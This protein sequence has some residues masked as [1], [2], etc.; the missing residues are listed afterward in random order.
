MA[1]VV[2]C[3][4]DGETLADALGSLRGQEPHELVVVDDGSTDA[5]TLGALEE[6][7]RDGVRV[8]R[9]ENGGLSAA[10]MAGVRATSARYVMPLDADDALAPGSLA[11]LADALDREP[12][13]VMA[14]GDIEVFGD[15][16]LRLKVGRRLD[17]WQIT[18]LNTLPVASMVR[19]DALLAVEGW[20]L[21]HGYEDWDLWMSFAERGWKGVHVPGIALR[22]RRREGRMLSDCLPRHDELVAELRSRHPELYRRRRS[23]WRRSSA[24]VRVRVLFPAV[25]ALPVSDFD[26]SRLYQLADQPRQFVEMRRRRRALR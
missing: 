11:R 7:D 24:P 12:A 14:W 22:Y 8:V 21:R 18:H 9:Q 1:V 25:S 6:L 19:R 10:R 23:N 13:A 20:Q 5:T 3:Y 26:K 17:P 15:V 4:D 2:P 16:E